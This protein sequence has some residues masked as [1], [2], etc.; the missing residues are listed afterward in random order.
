MATREKQV[1]DLA[2]PQPVEAKV[3]E[4]ETYELPEEARVEPVAEEAD[5][6]AAPVEPETKEEARSTMSSR[7]SELQSQIAQ[8]RSERKKLEE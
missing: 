4:D 7:V 6:E 3:V 2:P 1:K 5:E 8:E